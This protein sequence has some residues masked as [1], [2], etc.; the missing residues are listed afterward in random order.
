MSKPNISTEIRLR[1]LS[2]DM[3]QMPKC[4]QAV[5][6]HDELNCKVVDVLR[7]LTVHRS[8][9]YGAKARIAKG[10]PC[11]Q[12]GRPTFWTTEQEGT[13]IQIVTE[14]Y[15]E[16]EPPGMEKLCKQ[17]GMFCLYLV[18]LSHIEDRLH[19]WLLRSQML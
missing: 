1:A 13:L 11:G 19:F 6:I 4:E 2:M 17:V 9:Y 12:S 18:V 14:K 10:E 7:T 3:R 5:R 8:S 15:R 16:K